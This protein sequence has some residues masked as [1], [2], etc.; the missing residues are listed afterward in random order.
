MSD[1][2]P[3]RDMGRLSHEAAAVDPVTGFVYETED[4]GATSGFYRFVPT[5]P[6]VLANGGQLFML[7]V[8]N[9][10]LA[11]LGASYANGTTFDIEWV[12]IAT[13]DNPSS[14]APGNFVWAQG[15]A[16]GAATFARLE[17]CWYGNDRRIYIVSTSGGVT[18][19]QIWVYDPAA[20]TISLLFQSP[21]ADVLNMP[22]HHGQPARWS[23]PVRG[24]QWPRVSARPDG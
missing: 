7:K 4:A 3:L 8:K 20:E 2:V 16:L 12:P 13:P 5:T 10:A 9:V 17:G 24:R 19:G 18:Q 6:G 22:R 1:A 23:G 15:R 11:N 14:T 21:G